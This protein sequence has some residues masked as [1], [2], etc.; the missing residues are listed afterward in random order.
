MRSPYN[1]QKLLN[2]AIGKVG[3]IE[4]KGKADMFKELVDSFRSGEI[5][6]K[7]KRVYS[8]LESAEKEFAPPGARYSVLLDKIESQE[9]ILKGGSGRFR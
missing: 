6:Q 1:S 2:E 7:D 5:Y 3:K 9:D 4:D 8:V